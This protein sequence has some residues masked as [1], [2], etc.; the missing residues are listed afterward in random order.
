VYL[1]DTALSKKST[2]NTGSRNLK[3]GHFNTHSNG[4]TGTDRN[5]FHILNM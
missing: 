5:G 1:I 4:S 3:T 2:R